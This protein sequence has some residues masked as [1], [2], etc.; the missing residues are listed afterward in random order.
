MV[1]GSFLCIVGIA[2]LAVLYVWHLSFGARRGERKRSDRKHRSF[3][4][5]AAGILN[6]LRSGEF[7]RGEA[8]S[9]L[10]KINPYVFEEIVLDAFEDA[11]YKSIRNKAY[12]GDGGV[13]G[14]V[15]KDGEEWLVQCKRYSGYVSL[16]HVREF[17]YLCL[18][19]GKRGFFVHT[20][21]TG[22]V[23]REEL[24]KFGNVTLVSGERLFDLLGLS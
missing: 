2:L 23:S 15:R 16:Q 1:S 24:M 14:R 17:N 22:G 13:D 12:S 11:G 9:Y 3:R 5:K 20:G 7:R 6:K 19:E 8:I 10:R 21:K 4:K 18:R